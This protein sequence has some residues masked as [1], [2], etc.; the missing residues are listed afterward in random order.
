MAILEYVLALVLEV[1]PLLERP[2]H[3][4]YE[5]NQRGTYLEQ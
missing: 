1:A 4:R 2:S 3:P 5:L